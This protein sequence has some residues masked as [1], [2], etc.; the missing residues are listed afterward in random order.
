MKLSG[1]YEDPN[2]QISPKFSVS[3]LER[4]E[5]IVKQLEGLTI[6]S[7]RCLLAKISESLGDLLTLHDID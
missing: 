2:F 5:S 1:L 7:A 4:A 6:N 3:E